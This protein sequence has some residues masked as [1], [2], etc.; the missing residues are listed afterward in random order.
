MIAL[1]NP[2]T[3]TFLSKKELL[4]VIYFFHV[5]REVTKHHDLIELSEAAYKVFS[6]KD[7]DILEELIDCYREDLSIHSEPLG[8]AESIVSMLDRMEPE[9]YQFVQDIVFFFNNTH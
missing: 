5:L 7:A 3:T 9:E 2:V 8:G 6:D 4:E 1:P